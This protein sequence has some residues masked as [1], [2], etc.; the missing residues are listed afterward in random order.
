MKSIATI[1]IA[2]VVGVVCFQ[3]FGPTEDE[4][5]KMSASALDRL[6][7]EMEEV[8]DWADAKS[9]ELDPEPSVWEKFT[10]LFKGG[11]KEA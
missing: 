7:D 2:I 11:D 10:G 4:Y 8:Q 5:K 3:V 6:V 1:I 9:E